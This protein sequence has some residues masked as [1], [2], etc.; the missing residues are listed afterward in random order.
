MNVPA[1]KKKG[2]DPGVSAGV[3]EGAGNYSDNVVFRAEGGHGFAAEK[4]NHLADVL[5]GRKA[6]LVGGDNRL[7]GPDRVVNGL[8]IQSKYCRSGSKCIASCFRDGTYRYMG[9][10]GPMLIEVPSDKHAAAVQAMEHRIRTGQVPGV[11]D[12]KQAKAIVRKGWVTYAQARNVARFG[13]IESLTY[14]AVR[15]VRLAGTSMGVSAAIVFAVSVR[16]GDDAKDALRK[17]CVTGLQIG[18]L[19]WVSSV[20]A[21]QLGRTGVEQGLRG[22]TD[23]AVRQLGPKATSWLANGLYGGA[24]IYG[25]SAANH[26]SKVLRGNLAGGAVTAILLS[27]ADLIRLFRGRMSV[28]QML[29]NFMTTAAGIAGG[30]VGWMVGS[31]VGARI[32]A[33]IP[34]AGPGAG[35]LIGGVVGAMVFGSGAATAASGVLN[36]LIEDDARQMMGI[37]EES[38]GKLA[39]EYVLG[40]Q[41]ARAVIDGLLEADDLPVKLRDMYAA[42]DRAGFARRWLLPL[43]RE[44]AGRKAHVNLPPEQAI[45]R[46]LK[47]A[48]SS[49]AD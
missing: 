45:L 21:A 6:K 17:S 2:H 3:A 33:A 22:T 40:E 15:G 32:G 1:S 46:S 31:A 5:G 47:A 16:N 4:A 25:A 34:F 35:R 13:T 44:R 42:E 14:D 10:N 11:S 41:D 9:R 19:A 27:S 18:S 48:A 23:W 28:G 38:F 37:I 26:L 39:H 43:V 20:L 24:P 49:E 29:K 30:S 7:D 12:P 36:R 8:A